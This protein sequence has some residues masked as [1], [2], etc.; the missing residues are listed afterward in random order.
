MQLCPRSTAASTFGACVG[1]FFLAMFYRFLF[2][3][4]TSMEL[5]WAASDNNK[6]GDINKNCCDTPRT[7]PQFSIRTDL[8]RGLIE[9]LQSLVGYFLMLAVCN[10]YALHK[11]WI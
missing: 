3:F 4:R 10:F 1:L 2:A 8:P 6:F 9:G 7:T 11:P 5:K